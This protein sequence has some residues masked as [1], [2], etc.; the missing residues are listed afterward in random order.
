MHVIYSISILLLGLLIFYFYWIRKESRENKKNLFKK[1]ESYDFEVSSE[2]ALTVKNSDTAY[3]Y[4]DSDKL[5]TEEEKLVFKLYDITAKQ[6]IRLSSIVHP[7]QE[8]L[9][10]KLPDSDHF[11]YAKLGF[12]NNTNNFIPVAVSEAIAP[13]TT[14]LSEKTS[15]VWLELKGDKKVYSYEDYSCLV[16]EN[17]SK[18]I[19]SE[20]FNRD[21]K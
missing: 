10:I 18:T 5:K 9:F 14:T 17:L 2:L 12:Y 1:K 4:W 13:P 15:G 19:S 11:Y 8:E 3:A 7:E 6:K 21:N 20:N 16:R